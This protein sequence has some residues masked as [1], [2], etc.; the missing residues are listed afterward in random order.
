MGH[1]RSL[2]WEYCKPVGVSELVSRDVKW[3]SNVRMALPG[4]KSDSL[5]A[6]RIQTGSHVPFPQCLYMDDKEIVSFARLIFID[7][8]IF[9]TFECSLAQSLKL[10]LACT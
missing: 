5:R 7:I 4:F 10:V 6:I 9:L 3:I 2:G 1:S 8:F